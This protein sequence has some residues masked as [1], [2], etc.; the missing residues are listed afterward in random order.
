M[1]GYWGDACGQRPAWAGRTARSGV[2]RGWTAR[3]RCMGGASWG[4]G[5]SRGICMRDR[6]R[7]DIPALRVRQCQRASP[8]SCRAAGGDSAGRRRRVA[9]G[10]QTVV[11]GRV[12]CRLCLPG[13]ADGR[14]GGILHCCTGMVQHGHVLG[15]HLGP[16]GQQHHCCGPVPAQFLQ[17]L[18]SHDAA[19]CIGLKPCCRWL[20]S[21]DDWI[22]AGTDVDRV[23]THS[24]CRSRFVTPC[25]RW[26]PTFS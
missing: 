5:C 12:G 20:W 26:A 19:H 2:G 6:G 13:A 16:E 24:P 3:P 8:T 14:R 4:R 7:H 15:D 18:Q 21:S 9:S 17:E 11:S 23:C 1:P 25:G 10:Q 22:A